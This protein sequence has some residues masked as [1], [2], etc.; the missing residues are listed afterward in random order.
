[1]LMLKLMYFLTVNA[2]MSKVIN[3]GFSHFISQD[4]AFHKLR[5]PAGF[6]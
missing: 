3:N 6:V 5:V 4:E 2:K 1:M